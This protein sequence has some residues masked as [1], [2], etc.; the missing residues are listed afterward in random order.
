MTEAKS[1]THPRFDFSL[2]KEI[3]T[4]SESIPG[5]WT[6]Q[7][8]VSRFG[9]VSL[10]SFFRM[11]GSKN[12]HSPTVGL[13]DTFFDYLENS[14]NDWYINF[15]DELLFGAYGTRLLAQ[16][17]LQCVEIPAL[18]AT[19]EWLVEKSRT[20]SKYSALTRDEE[21]N[22]TPYLF[23]QVPRAF[24]FHTEPTEVYPHGFYGHRFGAANWDDVHR[25]IEFVQQPQ[26]V[27]IC[28]MEAPWP[29][30]GQYS[31]DDIE[32]GLV[33]ALTG[34]FAIREETRLQNHGENCQDLKVHTGNWGCGA[35]GGNPVLMLTIQV[36]AATLA[37]I[38]HLVF[39]K[40]AADLTEVKELA[41][42]CLECTS[43]GSLINCLLA[44]KFSWSKSDGN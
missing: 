18:I 31:F 2:K 23:W 20:D 34:M 27:N 6:H 19:R 7:I 21:K 38:P 8:G 3:F 41:K 26:L 40:P 35:Y 13:K 37:N 29:R 12:T 10:E 32:D 44:Q 14:T 43:G 42:K 28:A 1:Q 4:L 15:A 24:H 9:K 33:T 30:S 25:S 22:P 11:N 16:D 36:I 39:Y 5:Y 17:E